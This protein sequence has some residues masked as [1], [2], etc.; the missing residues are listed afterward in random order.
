MKQAIN[1]FDGPIPGQS[2]TTEPG[3]RPWEQPP[4]MN[5]PDEIMEA[6][7]SKMTQPKTAAR[8][9]ALMEAKIPVEGIVHGLL[10]TGFTEGKWSVDMMPLVAKPL[11]AL[12]LLMAKR[13]GIKPRLKMRENEPD[14]VLSRLQAMKNTEEEP[15]MAEPMEEPEMPAP[16]GGLMAPRGMM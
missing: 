14:P 3:N 1:P 4:Q 6:F 5:D 8:V 15:E 7:L 16:K 13:A 9:L 12:L 2:L 10:F 11:T